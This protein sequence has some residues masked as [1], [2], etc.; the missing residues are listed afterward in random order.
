MTNGSRERRWGA[1][2]MGAGMVALMALPGCDALKSLTGGGPAPAAGTKCD[3]SGA[4][5]CKDKNSAMICAGG[6]WQALPCRGGTHCMDMGGDGKDSCSNTQFEAGEPCVTDK[7]ECIAGGK[8]VIECKDNKW[9]VVQKCA[10]MNGCVANAQGWKCDMSTGDEG[11][12]CMAD[13]K[14]T[15]ACTTDKKTMLRCDGTKMVKAALCPGMHGCRK[16]F[17]KI[18]C[19]GEKPIK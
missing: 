6:T 8:A 19:N 18:E 16:S 11:D 14:D 2:A 4:V 15:Y 13:S 3:K 17:D 9:T 1:L 12:P 10:G 5:E 7:P